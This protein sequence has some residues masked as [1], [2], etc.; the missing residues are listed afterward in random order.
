MVKRPDFQH[1]KDTYRVKVELEFT[2]KDQAVAR[3]FQEALKNSHS[4]ADPKEEISW[5]ASRGKYKTS[6]YLKDKTKYG[7]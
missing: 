7:S 1:K 3:S 5:I 6:F 4:L 2:T